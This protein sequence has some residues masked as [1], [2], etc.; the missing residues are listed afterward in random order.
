MIYSGR[1]G[2]RAF[3]PI[4]LSIFK[5][6]T[7][8]DFACTPRLSSSPVVPRQLPPRLISTTRHLLACLLISSGLAQAAFAG[9]AA[10]ATPYLNFTIRDDTGN[11]IESQNVSGLVAFD[12]STGDLNTVPVGTSLKNWSNWS[13]SDI[14]AVTGQTMTNKILTWISETPTTE[15]LAQSIVQLKAAGNVDPFM[16]YSFSAKNNTSQNQHF[17]FSY[18]ESITPAVA[19]NQTIYAD[20]GGSLTRGTCSSIPSIT[21]TL[22]DLD[23]DGI[24]EIQTLKLSADG[25]ITFFDAGVD[26]GLAQTNS[27]A[28]NTVAFGTY[29]DLKTLNLSSA[30]DY[31]QFDVGF[32]LTPNKSAVAL[33][34]SA[35]LTSLTPI[36]EPSSYTALIGGIALIGVMVRRR[37]LVAV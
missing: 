19:G 12:S 32:T 35:E 9:A 23:S 4:L 8:M 21:P 20:I 28:A 2:A 1:S 11:V 31:W 24:Q 25:G 17:H 27:S 13:W 14:D 15:G 16:N 26:V 6:N 18:G 3:W 33:S 5:L 30:I 10:S 34:G 22:G 7:F 29:S 37:W 36:P